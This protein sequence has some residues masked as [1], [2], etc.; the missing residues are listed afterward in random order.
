[1]SVFSCFLVV[2]SS[3]GKIKK[4]LRFPKGL[5]E[6]KKVLWHEKKINLL[7]GIIVIKIA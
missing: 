3:K 5:I 6:E 1:M 2:G 7:T 4:K